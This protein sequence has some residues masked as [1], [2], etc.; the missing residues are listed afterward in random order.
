VPSNNLP[1]VEVICALQMDRVFVQIVIGLSHTWGDML[2]TA[3][4]VYV[5]EA[6]NGDPRQERTLEGVGCRPMLSEEPSPT[7]G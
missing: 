3:I 1:Q 2:I 6:G 7:T 5:E 4:I